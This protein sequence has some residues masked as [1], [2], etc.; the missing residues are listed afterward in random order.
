MED[1]K[2]WQ[3]YKRQWSWNNDKVNLL[4]S[5]IIALL[6][7]SVYHFTGSIQMEPVEYYLYGVCLLLMAQFICMIVI[8]QSLKAIGMLLYCSLVTYM[9]NKG[10]SRAIQ[11]YIEMLVWRQ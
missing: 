8:Y 4:I 2:F 1:F 6:L 7:T 5:L 11:I 9:A 10:D 3:L